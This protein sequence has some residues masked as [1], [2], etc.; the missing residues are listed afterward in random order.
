MTVTHKNPGFD[1]Q[2]PDRRF[3]QT[4]SAASSAHGNVPVKTPMGRWRASPDIEPEE[5]R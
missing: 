2:I 3:R 4:R 1:A 5:E